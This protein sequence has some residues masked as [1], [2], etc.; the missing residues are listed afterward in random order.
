MKVKQFILISF[1]VLGA[2]GLTRGQIA[3]YY[4]GTAYESMSPEAFEW[5]EERLKALDEV[6]G[7]SEDQVSEARDITVRYAYRVHFLLQKG[8][9]EEQMTGNKDNLFNPRMEEIQK[10][11][12]VDQIE[13]LSASW[14]DLEDDNRE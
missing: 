1:L 7:L 12:T 8:M 10:I 14:A 2:S 9:N 5:A 13:L 4:T 6:V 11:L 3:E